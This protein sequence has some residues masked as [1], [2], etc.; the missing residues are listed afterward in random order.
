[1]KIIQIA[2]GDL[3]AGAEV[4]L[5]HLASKLT[6]V[7]NL[8]LLVILLN[9]GQLANELR[10][11]NINLLVL[12]E[13]KLSSWLIFREIYRQ[14]RIFK[15]DLIHTHRFK[16]NIL[17]GIVARLCGS[18]SVRTMHGA[19]EIARS[20]FDYR[21]LLIN[22]LDQFTGRWLQHQVIAVSEELKQKLLAQYPE[23]HLSIIENSIDIDHIENNAEKIVDFQVDKQQFNICF[24]GRFVPVK[25]TDLFIDIA[26]TTLKNNPNAKIHFYLFGDGPLLAERQQQI[27]DAGLQESIT[28]VGFVNNIAPY[29]KQM[30]MLIFTSDHEGLPMTLLE[31]MALRVAI[32]S[33][34]LITIK[35]VLNN[36]DSG[37]FIDSERPEDFAN[38]IA[39]IL[40]NKSLAKENADQARHILQNKYSINSNI[41]HYTQLYERLIF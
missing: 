19:S 39:V 26:K 40:E 41:S 15:P 5:Y 31:A 16:E 2:S 8:E 22:G 11:N 35:Q 14:A 3:W 36:G 28:L 38:K 17:G 27:K 37:F 29:L 33:R 21:R 9:E 32:M 1:M 34:E 24:V 25:R 23:S 10:E 12:D 13:S 6:L 30:D 7:E 20:I 4:Q 18:K